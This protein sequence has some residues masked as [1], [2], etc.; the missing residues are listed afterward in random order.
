[1]SSR[2]YK[3]D[4]RWPVAIAL[5]VVGA[6]IALVT[7]WLNGDSW[8]AFGAVAAYSIAWAL[9]TFAVL[10][11]VTKA[12]EDWEWRREDHDLVKKFEDAIED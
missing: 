8:A 10:Y 2:N 1:M 4:L 9:V 12:F 5:C 11:P 3:R 7:R 6:A